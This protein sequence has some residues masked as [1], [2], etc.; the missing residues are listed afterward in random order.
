MGLP[1][2]DPQ[3]AALGQ[4]FDDTYVA[5]VSDETAG[6]VSLPTT[7]ARSAH[8]AHVAHTLSRCEFACA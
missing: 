5:R 7:I 3:G 8:V 6:L 4:I 1:T 2:G